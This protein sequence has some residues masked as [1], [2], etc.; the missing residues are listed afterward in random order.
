NNQL[1]GYPLPP[2][3]GFST[4]Q[5]YNLQAL[6]ENSGWEFEIN[7][8]NIKNKKLT[9]RTA[10]NLSIPKN[11]LVSF[12]NLSLSGYANKYEIGKPLTLVKSYHFLEVDPQ[13]GVYKYEDVNKDGQI[14]Y[15]EDLMPIKK[16][17]Q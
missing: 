6:V 11:K 12:P 7:S 10:F 13:T 1:V 14:T 4:I 9:W 15:P 5:Y 2:S 8:I 17:T 16:V 3:T